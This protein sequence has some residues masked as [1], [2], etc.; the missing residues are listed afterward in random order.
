[1]CLFLMI[2]RPPR[3]TRTDTLC[4]YTTLVRSLRRPRLASVADARPGG[5]GPRPARRR[6]NPP[7]GQ[8]RG[9]PDR[10]GD[11]RRSQPAAPAELVALR[12]GRDA[13]NTGAGCPPAGFARSDR[14][15]QREPRTGA[16][17]L[18]APPFSLPPL[19]RLPPLPTR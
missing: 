19:R 5:R 14:A 17:G 3:T 11:R 7:A 18:P 1:M 4:P 2:R 12:R 9:L 8:P 13:E 10:G 6:G 16:A 15:A